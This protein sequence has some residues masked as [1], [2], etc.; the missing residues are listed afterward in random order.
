MDAPPPVEAP[1]AGAPPHD[2]APAMD[3]STGGGAPAMGAS[4]GGGASMVD[5]SLFKKNLENKEGVHHGRPTTGGGTHG[6]RVHG[7]RLPF[8]KKNSVFL[9]FSTSSYSNVSCF[10]CVNHREFVA[11]HGVNGRNHLFLI[12]KC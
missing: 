1:M 11:V 4:T 3:A 6:T 10:W 5:G 12:M 7:G 2:E 8:L 9:K